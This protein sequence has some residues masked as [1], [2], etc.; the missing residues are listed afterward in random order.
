[1]KKFTVTRR[2]PRKYTAKLT[3][4]SQI[5]AWFPKHKLLQSASGKTG[6]T[7]TRA[8]ISK[9]RPSILT[10]IKQ[11]RTSHVP[12]L[13][14]FGAAVEIVLVRL[15]F[16]TSSLIV[17]LLTEGR[18]TTLTWSTRILFYK[19]LAKDPSIECFLI[20]L[21]FS[22]LKVLTWF[23]ASLQPGPCYI[24]LSFEIIFKQGCSLEFCRHL[25]E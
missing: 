19:K 7:R 20:F 18:M 13:T 16:E 25:Y 11:R 17:S 21:V 8:S 23:P 5:L 4:W 22:V 9:L 12:N 15:P 10:Q 3:A 1:M 2:I 14:H 24:P 6:R